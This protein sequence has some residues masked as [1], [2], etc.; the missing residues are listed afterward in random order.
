MLGADLT[1]RNPNRAIMQDG[2]TY[3]Y[4][5]GDQLLILQPHAPAKGFLYD[6]GHETLTPAA[7]NPA[8]AELALA[9]ALWPSWAYL[10]ERYRL[11]SSRAARKQY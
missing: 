7:L 8:L 6:R 3:G 2:D 4:L 1:Q 11:P 10:N 5:Q 9:H